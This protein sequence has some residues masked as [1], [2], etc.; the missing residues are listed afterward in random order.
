MKITETRTPPPAGGLTALDQVELSKEHR[1][2]LDN[3]M[4]SCGGG[5]PWKNNKRCNARDLLALS[6]ISGRMNV[7]EL[8]LAERFQALIFIE[9]P[10]PC[11]PSSDGELQ[12]AQGVLLG[13]T[14][15]QEALI[16]PQPGYS[17]IQILM[18]RGIWH[19]NAGDIEHGQ[20]LCL[21][22]QIPTAIPVTELVLMAYGALSLQA[23]QIDERD[24]AG[25]L[26]AAAARWWQQNRHLMP[27]TTEPFIRPIGGNS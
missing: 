21:G 2:M 25:V 19:A 26:N 6:Q 27:L 8:D 9:M 20:P 16:L 13:L 22:V 12:V 5:A 17:F 10:A 7:R 14:Y 4:L 15:P 11:T 23:V 24:H 3:A 1:K 18:P